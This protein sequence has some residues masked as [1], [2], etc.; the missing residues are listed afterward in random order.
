MK[1][2]STLVAAVLPVIKTSLT[3]APPPPKV[4]D[5]LKRFESVPDMLELDHLTVTG[6]VY[7]GRGVSLRV[8]FQSSLFAIFSMI[9][10]L[11]Y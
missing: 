8:G 6:E 5:F 9:L 10:F 1:L 2:Q 11:N 4:K 3:H 7:F